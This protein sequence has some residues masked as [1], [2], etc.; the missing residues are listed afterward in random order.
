MITALIIAGVLAVIGVAV[1]LWW[2]HSAQAARWDL[3]ID[4]QWAEMQ[5]EQLGREARARMRAAADEVRNQQR[6][7]RP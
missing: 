3:E 6:S 1:F 4:R 5:I 2:S 7:D